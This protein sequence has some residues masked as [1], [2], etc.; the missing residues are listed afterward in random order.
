MCYVQAC[1]RL[2]IHAHHYYSEHRHIDAFHAIEGQRLLRVMHSTGEL[3]PRKAWTGMLLASQI[4]GIAFDQAVLTA[5]STEGQRN[6]A[7]AQR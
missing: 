1:E 5:R 3:S 7:G 2:G 4:T 6:C